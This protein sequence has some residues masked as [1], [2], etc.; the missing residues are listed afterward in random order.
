M[1]E[2]PLGGGSHPPSVF[3]SLP[4]TKG[5]PGRYRSIFFKNRP[6]CESFI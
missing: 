2:Y 1:R 6:V 5:F 3:I 4:L